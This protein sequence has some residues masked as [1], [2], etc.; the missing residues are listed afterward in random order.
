M[1]VCL[2]MPA[3]QPT[4]P[5][6]VT[7]EVT[8]TANLTRVAQGGVVNVTCDVGGGA[9]TTFTDYTYQWMLEGVVLSQE[10]SATLS[11]SSFSMADA[12]TYTCL[13]MNEAGDGMDSITIKLGGS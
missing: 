11:L 13:V 2:C 8:V 10:S 7:L 12:G 1:C 9:N 3:D 5:L 6:L 4:T